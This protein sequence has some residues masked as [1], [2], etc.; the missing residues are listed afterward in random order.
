MIELIL[1]VLMWLLTLEPAT[2]APAPPTTT[3]TLAEPGYVIDCAELD[4]EGNF[5]K[6]IPCPFQGSTP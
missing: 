6:W 1:A 4:N 2:P 3:T 5:V